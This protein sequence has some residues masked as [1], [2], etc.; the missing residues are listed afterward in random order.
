MGIKGFFK[1]AFDDMKQNAKAQHAADKA[2][3]QAVKAEA[4]AHF[5]ENRGHN[6][7]QKAKADAKRSWDD[8]HMSPSERTEKCRQDNAKRVA[9]AKEKTEVANARYEAA[10]K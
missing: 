1:Q 6:T 3:F 7:F 4:K 9:A 2:E 10:K 5:E 8:A